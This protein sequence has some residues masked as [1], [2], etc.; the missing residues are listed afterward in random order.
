MKRA[1]WRKQIAV[2][3]NRLYLYPTPEP[4]PHTRIFWVAMG[5]VTLLVALF[6]GYF[7]FYLTGRHDAF[8]T[9][10]E[11]LGIMD[12]AVWNTLHGHMLHMTICNGV[13]D[14]NC[15]G[16]QGIPRFAIHFEPILFLISLFYLF[17]SNPKML[18]ILQ[19]LIVASGAYPAFW[20]A[21][22]RL[23]NDLAA[24]VIALLYLLYPAQQQATVFDFH[25]VTLTAALLLFT[26]YFMYTRQTLWLFVFAILSM[27]CKEEIPT[28]IIF[29]G[30]WSMLLQQRARSG[31]ALAVLG[32]CWLGAVYLAF[33]IFSPTGHPLLASRYAYLGSSPLSIARAVLL[34]P[35]SI[36]IGHVL[37]P[38]HQLY[39][40]ILLSPA[41]NLPWLAPWALVLALPSLAINL[42]SSE[43]NQFSGFFQYN[44]EIVP[45]L[46]FA[47][48][49]AMAL[50]I[51]VAQW[52]VKLALT[53]S[54]TPAK[55]DT[56]N[57][58]PQ[59]VRRANYW[60]HLALLALLMAYVTY[61]V[62]QADYTYG[63]L[64]ISSQN[65]DLFYGATP[66]SPHFQWP[67]TT[68]HD[69]LAQ[70]F[71]NMI[72]QDASV[73]A[74][75]HLAPHVSERTQIYLFPYADDRADYIFLDVTGNTY[76]LFSY[77]YIH[78]VKKVLFSGNYGI[79]AA[80]D[81]Y[82][83]LKRGLPAPGISPYSPAQSGNNY[84]TLLPNLPTSFCSYTQVAPSAASNSLDA[85][86]SSASG[87]SSLDLVGV[88]VSAAST[89][90][91]SGSP[92]QVMTYWKVNTPPTIPVWMA[93][94]ITDSNGQQHFITTDFPANTWCPVNTWQPGKVIFIVS[95]LF[96]LQG[97]SMPHGL[98]HVSLV[99]LPVTHP[100]S[101]IMNGQ[102]R[103]SVHVQQA[104]S[105]IVPDPAYHALQVATLH[106]V[107]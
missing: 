45:V 100:Y 20:L 63:A 26:L 98:A 25:A 89:F 93:V 76:P 62:V 86:F 33:R 14:T 16:Y 61:S 46:I 19:T 5:L 35:R 42:L 55:N 92:M 72:P 3:R 77:Q 38:F 107:S 6:A 68:A 73:S 95:D 43:P 74:Q 48:I 22:L 12:Q 87:A 44:A 80:Q 66:F 67:Q 60:I 10:A 23:R 102:D 21:R 70:Q 82:L 34:H 99:L 71:I 97:V 2:G 41:G 83:L 54:A 47:T 94:L 90:S 32:V 103:F 84:D 27:A 36:F 29:F 81:G 57:Q 75:S 88:N 96:L 1:G 13:S 58:P 30:L 18:L 53:G 50:I 69:K 65:F 9:S 40:H 59:R 85:T 91:L 51:W 31:L 4:M 78:E 11:D 79:L 106:I 24:V 28:V 49:E 7:I 17:W 15:N 105:T 8:I 104:P 52:A 64:P 101:T 39:L 37:E 56:G